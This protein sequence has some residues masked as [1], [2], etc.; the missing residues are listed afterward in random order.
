M[1]VVEV[2]QK[3]FVVLD[4]SSG[5]VLVESIKSDKVLEGSFV[6]NTGGGGGGGSTNSWLTGSG[7]PGSGLG[8]VNDFYLDSVSGN[9]YQKTNSTTWTIQGSLIGPQGAQGTQGIQGIQGDQ[10]IQGT[11]GPQGTQGV[12]GI[13]GPQG[14]TGSSGQG[15]PTGGTSGQV[16][17]KNSNTDFDASWITPSGGGGGVTQSQSIVNALIFG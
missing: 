5:V 7:V 11:Q 4:Q 17:T 9:Y 3:Q 10:G 12:Q 6:I 8:S 16:L 13:Q 14:N 1:S 15:V 2:S